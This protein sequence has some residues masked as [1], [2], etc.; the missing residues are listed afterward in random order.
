MAEA[1]RGPPP[2]KSNDDAKKSKAAEKEARNAARNRVTRRKLEAAEGLDQE[3][4]GKLEDLSLESS[5]M[6]SA[7]LPPPPPPRPPLPPPSPPPPPPPLPVLSRPVHLPT[8]YAQSVAAGLASIR[9]PSTYDPI[10]KLVAISITHG[11]SIGEMDCQALPYA[12][13][14][15][16]NVFFF[17]GSCRKHMF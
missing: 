14:D 10:V 5:R 13:H 11:S 9:Q 4:L 17:W 15:F 12:T 16:R 1:G 7:A 6:S 8:S 3:L 2:N